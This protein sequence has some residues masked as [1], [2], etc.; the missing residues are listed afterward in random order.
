[1][2]GMEFRAI[3]MY[4][5]VKQL[6]LA[7]KVGLINR[8]SIQN[9]ERRESVPPK[10]VKVLSD[11]IGLNLL[12]EKIFQKH[13]EEIPESYKKINYTEQPPMNAGGTI[14]LPKSIYD[15]YSE[16]ELEYYKKWKIKLE[17]S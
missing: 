16:K 9:L 11:M 13:Y 4:N 3:R 10:Y 12:D 17:V 1:M 5:R 8:H 15:T 7:Y 2:K 14:R 6:D